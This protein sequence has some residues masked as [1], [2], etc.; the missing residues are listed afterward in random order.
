MINI[1]E[2]AQ[3]CVTRRR[4]EEAYSELQSRALQEP[5]EI[6]LNGVDLLSMSFLDG[7][8]VKLLNSEQTNLVTF[9]SDEPSV[10]HKL[11]RIA[12][13]RD[14]E[15]FHRGSASATRQIV[16]TAVQSV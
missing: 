11:S 1:Y 3:P 16:P 9:V 13:I 4:G 6:A 8:I 7:L 15:L 10:L 12:D 2:L 5:I 14:V